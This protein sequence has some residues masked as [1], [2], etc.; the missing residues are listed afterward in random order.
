MN[1]EHLQINLSLYTDDILTDEERLM[2]DKHLA[3][4]PLCR[5]KLSEYQELTQNLRVM[6]RAAMPDDLL[7]SIRTSVVETIQKDETRPVFVFRDD[8]KDNFRK[9]WRVHLMSYSIGTV[10]SLVLGFL[11]LTAIFPGGEGMRLA[12][13]DAPERTTIMLADD[14]TPMSSSQYAD[15]LISY[16]NPTI[17][18]AGALAAMSKSIMRGKMTNEEI[19][20]VADVFGNG[21]AQIAEVVEPKIDDRSVRELEKA[22]RDDPA[23]SAPPFVPAERDKRPETVR[24]V[25]KIQKVDV[26]AY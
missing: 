10:A 19:V 7:A 14:G 5:V 2:L 3:A 17:N 8:F 20:V 25:L 11:L 4:C 6:P 22:L 9:W 23:F 1:C 21:L 18:P 16:E 26:P 15:Q 13:F 12:S 24:V